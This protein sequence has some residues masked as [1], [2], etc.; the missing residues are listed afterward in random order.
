MEYAKKI[1][2]NLCN[3]KNVLYKKCY[4]EKIRIKLNLSFREV[5]SVYHNFIF[6][7]Q[8]QDNSKHTGIIVIKGIS[9]HEIYWPNFNEKEK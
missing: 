1:A 4:K 6:E 9:L 7:F 5:I 2:I 8:A 3:N